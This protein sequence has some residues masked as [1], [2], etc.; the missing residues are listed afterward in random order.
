MNSISPSVNPA[1]YSKPQKPPNSE[2]EDVTELHETA[3]FNSFKLAQAKKDQAKER[4]DQLA[5]LRLVEE[6]KR[7]ESKAKKAE[8]KLKE[9]TLKFIIK[10][11][12]A[13]TEASPQNVL[14]ERTKLLFKDRISNLTLGNL[15]DVVSKENAP[16][17][18]SSVASELGLFFTSG[19]YSLIGKDVTPR[20][21]K[22]YGENPS[23]HSQHV[24][25]AVRMVN[26]YTEKDRDLIVEAVKNFQDRKENPSKYLKRRKL[27]PCD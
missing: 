4:E 19:E 15:T 7:I 6:K 17:T 14:D 21:V 3:G 16:I 24:E 18:I 1:M 5:S 10:G 23:K 2:H 25:G 8:L 12:K 22:R 26:S 11:M 20:Y 13:C 27:S 9:R